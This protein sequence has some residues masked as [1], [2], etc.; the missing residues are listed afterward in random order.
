MSCA[1]LDY[2]FTML[3]A[4]YQGNVYHSCLVNFLQSRFDFRKRKKKIK[5]EKDILTSQRRIQ[6]QVEHLQ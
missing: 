2:L 1:G 4:H 5:K 6:N 3:E